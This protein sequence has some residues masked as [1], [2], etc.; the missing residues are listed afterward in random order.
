MRRRIDL[1]RV[2]DR[3]RSSLKHAIVAVDRSYKPDAMLCP[4]DPRTP[5]SWSLKLN[6]VVAL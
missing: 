3:L 4:L 1:K 5:P 2:I 6:Y